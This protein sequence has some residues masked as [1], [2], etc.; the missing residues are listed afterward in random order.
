MESAGVLEEERRE[1][2][3]KASGE[4]SCSGSPYG[5]MGWTQH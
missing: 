3:L 4:V 5:G 2:K 1:V